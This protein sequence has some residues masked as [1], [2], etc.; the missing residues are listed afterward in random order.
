M[1]KHQQVWVCGRWE[2]CCDECDEMYA[3][4]SACPF[5]PPLPP[6]QVRKVVTALDLTKALLRLLEFMAQYVPAAFLS[7]GCAL[8]LTR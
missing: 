1:D 3:H 7:P 5:T 6:S 4:H 2:G 8:N